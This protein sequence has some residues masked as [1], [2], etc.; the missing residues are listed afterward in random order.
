MPPADRPKRCSLRSQHF[1]RRLRLALACHPFVNIKKAVYVTATHFLCFV[2]GIFA[3]TYLLEN[4]YKDAYTSKNSMTLIAHYSMYSEIQRAKGGSEEYRDSLF[5][6]LN[7]LELARSEHDLFFSETAYKTD[8]LFVYL[9]LSEVE[10]SLGNIEKSKK[11]LGMA[12]DL[13]KSSNWDDCTPKHLF[14]M[15]NK[16]DEQSIFL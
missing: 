14:L 11:H 8:K 2:L 6:F 7:A 15:V 9:R 4:M 10:K 16:L 1:G 12:V 5:V 3:S 13:C